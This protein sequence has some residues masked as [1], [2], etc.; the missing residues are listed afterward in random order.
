M[1]DPASGNQVVVNY[2]PQT[3]YVGMDA[4]VVEVDDGEDGTVG[5]PLDVTANSTSSVLVIT[6]GYSTFRIKLRAQKKGI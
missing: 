2:T 3:D 6:K 5:I 4:F 1:T